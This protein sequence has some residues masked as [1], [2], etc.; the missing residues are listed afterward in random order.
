MFDL[1]AD[2]HLSRLAPLIDLC[3]FISNLIVLKT[4]THYRFT[5]TL[6]FREIISPWQSF[7]IEILC[8]IANQKIRLSN[9][10]DYLDTN[11]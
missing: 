3:V 6:S 10:C 5:W 1:D 2:E 8:H 11:K 7:K 9:T 4:A